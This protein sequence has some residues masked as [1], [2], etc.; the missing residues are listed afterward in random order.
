[1]KL[2][3][4]TLLALLCLHAPLHALAPAW[5]QEGSDLKPD[6]KARFGRLENGFRYVILPNDEPPGR[7]SL[8]LYMDV[9]S[10][11]EA[12]D[13]QGMAHFLEHM[14]F[15]GTKGYPESED[16]VEYFQHLGM[17]FGGDTNAHTSF[18][19]TVYQLEIPKVDEKYFSD[20]IKL[21]RDYLDGMLL[22][23]KEIDKERGI[24]LS[25]KLSRDSVDY[26]TMLAGFKF[27]MPDALIS[28]RMP[29]GQ[30]NT[31]KKMTPKR[32]VDFY[33]TYYTPQRAIVVVVGDVKD[34]AMVEK[35][36]QASFKDAKP[37]RDQSP[38]PDMGKVT[39]GRG[40]IAK[41]HS[42]KDAP[43]TDIS[44]ELQRP[45]KKQPDTTARRRELMVRDLADLML[46]TRFSKLAKAEGSPIMSGESYSYEYLEFVEVIGVMTKCKPENWKAALALIEQ[47]L[48][49]GI[50][51]GFTDSELEEAKASLLKQAKLRAAV[52]ERG[53]SATRGFQFIEE[54]Q[55]DFVHRNFVIQRHLRPQEQHILLHT[56][57]LHAQRDDVAEELLRHQDIHVC[58]RFTHFLD[59]TGIRHSRRIVDE[60]NLTAGLH[61]L[62]DYGRRGGNQIEIVFAFQP[63]LNDLHVQHAEEAAAESKTERIG[64]LGL[65]KQR[66]VVQRQFCQRLAKGFVIF[67]GNR[68]KSRIHLRLHFFEARQCVDIGRRG[69]RQRIADRRPLNFLDTRDDKAHLA[70]AQA[71]TFGMFWRKNT[72]AVDQLRLADRL[73]DD[74]VALFDRAVLDTYQ[75]HNAEIIVEPRVDDQ[76]LQR[77]LDFTLGRRNQLDQLLQQILNAHT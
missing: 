72:N 27:A 11:M 64:N 47:E 57:P 40:L 65:V 26:R 5:P 37:R 74:L 50:Q 15:N 35:M 21:F 45:S 2:F 73:G 33:E 3:P 69:V 48:R 52:V 29:I 12:D 19:E 49:R 58:D 71:I 59:F 14:A 41:L 6:P 8:R 24:I 34:P 43:A 76:R 62:I 17:S 46:N 38:D 36:I 60:D 68:E 20:A 66:C 63:L 77:R 67:R 56:T 51:F 13:Q 16:M 30:E 53:K 70:G 10:L 39:A 23:E 28:G 22:R 61:D 9:G 1:M 42:E 54:V 18:R 4:I 31:I 32:F 25:E 44:I 7:A 55:D 75:R